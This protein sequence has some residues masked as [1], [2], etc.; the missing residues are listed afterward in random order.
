[1]YIY[2]Y[3]YTYGA[4]PDRRTKA[5]RTANLRTKILDLRGFYSSIVLIL[6]GGTLMSIGISWKCSVSK[7]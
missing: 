4:R 3:I 6:R 1:M 2:I 5:L 7:S